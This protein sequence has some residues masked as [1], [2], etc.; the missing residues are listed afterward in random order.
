MD[1]KSSQLIFAP[2]IAVDVLLPDDLAVE[3]HRKALQ[4]IAAGSEEV[5]QLDYENGEILVQ[6]EAGIRLLR[7]EQLLESPLL[8]GFSVSVNTLLAT[9]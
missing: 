6:T 2:D 7:G 5:W 3:V 1:W 8:P 9:P 4:Y